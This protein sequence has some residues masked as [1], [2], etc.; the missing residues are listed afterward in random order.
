MMSVYVH[1]NPLSLKVLYVLSFF[2]LSDLYD[3]TEQQ[4]ETDP[5][6]EAYIPNYADTYLLFTRPSFES[7][8]R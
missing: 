2:L 1:I 3:A 8:K 6:T 4:H 7:K 5:K